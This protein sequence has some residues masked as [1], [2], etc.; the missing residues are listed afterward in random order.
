MCVSRSARGR[1]PSSASS[2]VASVDCGPGSTRMPS[3]SKQQMTFSRPRWSRSISRIWLETV[4]GSR[5]LQRAGSDAP[6]RFTPARMVARERP[7]AAVEATFGSEGGERVL[8]IGTDLR[9]RPLRPELGLHARQLA[10]NVGELGQARQALAPRVERVRLAEVIEHDGGAA[11]G[12]CE[13]GQLWQLS[14]RDARVED[15]AELAGAGDLRSEVVEA[16]LA[17][18]HVAHALHERPTRERVEIV[19]VRDDPGGHAERLDPLQLARVAA[20]GLDDDQLALAVVGRQ[21]PPPQAGGQPV[22]VQP[23]G[24]PEVDVG[25]YDR[26]VICGWGWDA[27]ARRGAQRGRAARRRRGLRSRAARSDRERDRR[28]RSR[29]PEREA[30]LE[31]EVDRVLVVGAVAD[32]EVLAGLEPEVAAAHADEHRPLH[33]GRAHERAAG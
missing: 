13:L 26:A 17:L 24:V 6:Y 31:I 4:D 33:P 27:R 23:A 20:V 21:E 29:H 30:L 9:L 10:A 12:A 22:V 28:L 5:V 2:S 32:R 3:T 8:E 11:T 16:R 19:H 14:L 25:V 1:S 15:E 7:V 18:E